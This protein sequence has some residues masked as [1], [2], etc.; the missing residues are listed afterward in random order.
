M[1]FLQDAPKKDPRNKVIDGVCA[2]IANSLEIDPFWV[3]LATVLL[4]FATGGF[5]IV[6]YIVLTLIMKTDRSTPQEKAQTAAA[7]KAASA[8][9]KSAKSRAKSAQTASVTN[10]WPRWHLMTNDIVHALIL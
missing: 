5:A 6:V 10:R 4:A 7:K 1:N 3:R 2:G 9:S 8:K